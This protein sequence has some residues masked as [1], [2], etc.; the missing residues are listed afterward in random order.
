MSFAITSRRKVTGLTM[1]CGEVLSADAV[2][3]AMGPWSTLVSDSYAVMCVASDVRMR[4]PQLSD[5]GACCSDWMEKVGDW[6]GLPVPM[7]GV[8]S[9]SLV[10]KN[11]EAVKAEPYALF[12]AEDR[13]GCHLEVHCIPKDYFAGHHLV[14]G[15]PCMYN[16]TSRWMF[17][18][19][20]RAA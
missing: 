10:Y 18:S 20:A 1:D 4:E 5:A 16:I 15:H 19:V 11:C 14:E 7:E 13:N 8:K 3:F 2:V 6:L 17:W 12:C 9:T